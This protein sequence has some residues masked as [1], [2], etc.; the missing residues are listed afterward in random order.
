MQN[1]QPDL[2]SVI[3]TA[4]FGFCL[5]DGR[6]YNITYA[7]PAFG[8]LIGYRGII[9]DR[10]LTEFLGPEIVAILYSH[11]RSFDQEIGIQI[12]VTSQRWLKVKGEQLSYKGNTSYALWFIDVTAVKASE[13]SLKSAIRAS[14]AAA[15]MKSNLLATM[16]H[17]IRTPMQA[18]YGFLELIGEEKLSPAV[19][20][21][22]NTA[23]SAGSGLLEILDDV[24]DLAKLDADKMELDFFEVPVRML[25][26]GT[27]EALQVK[28]QGRSV[29][30]LDDIAQDVPFVVKGDPKRLRQI[31]VNFMSNALKFTREGSVTVK[32]TTELKHVKIPDGEL[33]LRFEVIDTGMGMPQHVCDKLFK[34]FTQADSSTTRKF[35]GTGLG[36]SICKKL[37]ELMGGEI[38]VTSVEGKGSVFWFEIP[39]A[40]VN[41]NETTLQLPALEGLAV[42]VVE[43]H[44]QGQREIISSLRSMGAEV[45]ACATYNE[46][47]ELAKRRPFD[48]AIIDHGLPD[49]WGLDLMRD[50]AEVRPF[51]GLIMYSVHDDYSLQ[52]AIR[53]MGATYLSKPA[54]RM[55]LGEA[56]KLTAAAVGKQDM[57]GP[58]RLLI[59]EDT[60]AVRDILK[61]Q[62]KVIGVDDV[63]FVENGAEALKALESG[64]YGI[65]FTDLHMPEMDGYMLISEIR[66]QEA[67]GKPHLP[68]IVLTADVQMAQRQTYLKEGFDECLLKPVSLGQLRRLLVRW[69]LL[70]ET[71]AIATMDKTSKLGTPGNAAQESNDVKPAIDLEAMRA[72]MGVVDEGTIEMMHMFVDMTRPLVGKIQDAAKTSD[73][74]NLE[75]AAHSL[76]GA[77]R[78]AC[79]VIL[80]D[81]AAELQERAPDPEKCQELVQQI[82]AEFA[83]VES[84]I[85]ELET[86]LAA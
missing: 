31:I 1:A 21:M 32:V 10:T 64:Q 66:K 81:F 43:D 38:G 77:A 79:C 9:R 15:E 74:H 11:P 84:E 30:L 69:G 41:T 35:G 55:G 75:E 53:S 57:S 46:G 70:D 4:P 73:A 19:L 25:V 59:A 39:T 71:A 56:V 68:V 65:L 76:K 48:V 16:S 82:A 58:N 20:E 80:G 67:A 85:K 42:L 33:G 28:R 12:S 37:V 24:L 22:V 27:V 44:P 83:R 3:D 45:E 5:V 8:P 18:V 40:A 54:S 63:D 36:L 17:E 51:T 62:L 50:I 23:K 72:H 34:P 7:N 13:E 60:D 2:L 14:E 86:A 52:H 6:S 78:S 29:A 47:L 49:G 61:R 26:R